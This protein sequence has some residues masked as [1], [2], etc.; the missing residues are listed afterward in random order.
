L[1]SR[2]TGH[3]AA[4]PLYDRGHLYFVSRGIAY[5]LN[6]KSGEIVYQERLHPAAHEVFASPVLADGKLFYV[7]REGGAYVLAAGPKFQQLAH[8]DL[9]DRSPFNASPAPSGSRLLLRS[10]RYLYCLGQK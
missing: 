8:N 2:N 9:G 5:C 3:V 1:W 6:A 7:A 10:D 4:S